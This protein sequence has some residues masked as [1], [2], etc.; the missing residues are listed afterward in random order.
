MDTIS[1]NH[2]PH[3]RMWIA[4]LGYVT[5]VNNRIHIPFL[6]IYIYNKSNK[7]TSFWIRYRLCLHW[8]GWLCC[9]LVQH[10]GKKA[11]AM[12]NQYIFKRSWFK[13]KIKKCLNYNK[14]TISAQHQDTLG[15]SH[16]WAPLQCTLMLCTC[17]TLVVHVSSPKKKKRVKRNIW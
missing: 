11:K 6:Y 9:F 12:W 16:V 15:D 5:A 7:T 17:S 2:S 4:F 14:C 1:K 3:M 8:L 10:L 13:K